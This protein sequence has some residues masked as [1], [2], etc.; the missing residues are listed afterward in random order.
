MNNSKLKVL[1]ASNNQGK[2]N[3][4]QN[5]ANSLGIQILSPKSLGL[6]ID[7]V[8]DGKDFYENAIKKVKAYLPYVDDSTYVIGD[9]SG[10]EIPAL[11]GE[12]GVYT[13]RWAGHEMADQEIVDYC[14]DKM[15]PYSGDDRKAVFK[16]VLALGYKNEPIQFFEGELNGIITTEPDERPIENG[17]PFRNI[18]YI[19]EINKLLLDIH[20]PSVHVKTHRERALEK[21]LMYLKQLAIEINNK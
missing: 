13:R 21:L 2:I 18:F 19:P 4:L 3:E 15:K 9:D 20:D 6:S 14:L 8:E 16:T 1:F 12:P 5:Y 10:I 17:L 11:G 7:V